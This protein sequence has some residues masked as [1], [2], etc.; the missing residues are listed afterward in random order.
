MV[1]QAKVGAAAVKPYKLRRR[2]KPPIVGCV[3]E[4]KPC[5]AFGKTRAGDR[6]ARYAVKAITNGAHL[7]EKW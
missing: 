1:I 6:W 7:L 5:D 3:I 2:C 4:A